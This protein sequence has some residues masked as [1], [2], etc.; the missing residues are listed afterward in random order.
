MNEE[1]IRTFTMEEVVG[2]LNQMGPFKAPGLD[3]FPV[4]FFQQNWE[5]MGSEVCSAV[6]DTLNFDIMPFHLNMTHIVLI[7]KI[8]DTLKVTD[9]RPISLYNVLYKLISKLLANHLK[10]VL[11]IIIYPTQSA[12]IPGHLIL[13]NILAAY[14]TLHTMHSRMSRKK[15]FMAMKLNLSKAYNRVEWR[16]LEAT[17]GQLGFSA[18][19][20]K[21]IMMC[22]SMVKYAVLVNGVPCRHITPTRGIRQRDSI[23]PYLLLIYAEAL[24]FMIT[25]ANNDGLL[26]GVSTSKKGTRISHL[27][28]A[29]HSLLFCRTSYLQ[30]SNLSHILKVY[31]AASGQ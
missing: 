21:L 4:G 8:K 18:R 5:M 14:K 6:L 12:F 24:S 1:L 16:F 7:P 23:S 17:I 28:F 29:N 25:W 3:G 9:F 13:D 10:R 22:V 19:C 31:E 26:T 27:F 20:I 11:P 15:G 2:A 30:W